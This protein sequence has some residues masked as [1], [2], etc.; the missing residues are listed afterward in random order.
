MFKISQ[1]ATFR[2]P[3]K[4]QTVA[5]DGRQEAQSFDAEFKRLTQTRLKEIADKRAEITDDD[6]CRE[7][8]LGWSGI[9]DED[10]NDL[11]FSESNRDRLLDVMGVPAQIIFAFYDAIN[12]ARRK[13]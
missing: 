11:P 12:G 3:V 6:F 4:F 10:G 9:K 7:V 8:L 2:W 5:Q 1:S 13:N